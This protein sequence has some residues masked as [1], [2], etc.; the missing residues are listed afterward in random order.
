MSLSGFEPLASRIC[1]DKPQ[2]DDL[3]TNRQGLNI[4]SLIRH[5]YAEANLLTY[6][7]P[8]THVVL[9]GAVS[10]IPPVAPVS[11]SKL[12]FP[13]KAVTFYSLVVR[14][15][16]LLLLLAFTSRRRVAL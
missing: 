15:P 9:G 7:L 12:T 14:S 16:L 2:R 5:I 4:A 11:Q 1:G 13:T 8:L 3:T 6:S 10:L